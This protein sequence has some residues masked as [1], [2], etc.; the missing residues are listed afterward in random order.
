MWPCGLC[1]FTGQE[2]SAVKWSAVVPSWLTRFPCP[3]NVTQHVACFS[4]LLQ[5]E[6]FECRIYTLRPCT[7]EK[8]CVVH[9]ISGT[10]L[11]SKNVESDRPHILH[12]CDLVL[13]TPGLWVTSEFRISYLN[14]SFNPRII[15][16]YIKNSYRHFLLLKKKIDKDQKRLEKM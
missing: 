13:D 9:S 8:L 4:H 15:N 5:G 7:W 16:Q 14:T 3:M 11:S 10:P 2:S 1:L 6:Q 12:K